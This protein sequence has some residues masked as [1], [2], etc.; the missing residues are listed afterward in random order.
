ME[1][2]RI[3]LEL[4]RRIEQRGIARFTRGPQ[5]TDR[6]LESAERSGRRTPRP[7]TQQTHYALPAEHL[8]G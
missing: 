8:V 5:L 7:S 1:Q 6:R 2:P 3:P 4:Q